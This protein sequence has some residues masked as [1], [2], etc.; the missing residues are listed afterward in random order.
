MRPRLSRIYARFCLKRRDDVDLRMLIA[1]VAGAWLMTARD[2]LKSLQ[3]FLDFRESSPC[4]NKICEVLTLLLPI[5]GV[6][7]LLTLPGGDAGLSFASTHRAHRPA[8]CHARPEARPPA[9][10]D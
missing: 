4:V 9:L 1:S 7:S 6:S 2:R 10:V 8:S 5:L 3:D